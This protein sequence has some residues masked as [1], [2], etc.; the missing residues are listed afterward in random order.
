MP[1]NPHNPFTFIDLF[2]GIGGMRQGFDAA[3]GRCVFALLRQDR[4]RS[5]HVPRQLFL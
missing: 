2:A 4:P 5:N 3:G 1:L